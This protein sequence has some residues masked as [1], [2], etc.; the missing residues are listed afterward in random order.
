MRYRVYE[1]RYTLAKDCA[2]NTLWP[3]AAKFRTAN[4][5]RATSPDAN[6]ARGI[7]LRQISSLVLFFFIFT[8]VDMLRPIGTHQYS[9]KLSKISLKLDDF[10]IL[11]QSQV[12]KIQHQIFLAIRSSLSF[13]AASSCSLLLTKD[14]NLFQ[15]VAQDLLFRT[16]SLPQNLRYISDHNLSH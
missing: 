7:V 12:F 2:S 8:T 9:Q 6:P 3:S 4:A 10:E 15:E 5:S 13:I 16:F 14:A 11:I 1:M